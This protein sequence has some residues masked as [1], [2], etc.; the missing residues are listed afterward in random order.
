MQA[1]SRGTCNINLAFER[2][3]SRAARGD[4]SSAST[5]PLSRY[6][7]TQLEFMNFQG[8][9]MLFEHEYDSQESDV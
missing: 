9:E 5:L 1:L 4:A 6:F 2:S 7:L 8:R 3:T